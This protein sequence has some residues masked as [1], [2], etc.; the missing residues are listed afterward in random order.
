MLVQALA[1]YADTYMQKELGD[2]AFEKKPVPYAVEI[3]EQGRYLGVR[4]RMKEIFSVGGG[5]R[6]VPE[7]LLA[8]KSP[9][10]R[11]TG[12]HPLLGCDA[13]QYVVGPAPGVWTK[14]AEVEKH[15]RQ[16]AGFVELI[17]HSA[18]STKDNALNACSIFYR[19]AKS[20]EQARKD[21]VAKKPKPGAVALVV[22]PHGVDSEMVG[23]AIVER[24]LVQDY[25][26]KHFMKG[27]ED[28]HAR[29][30][31]GMCLVSGRSGRI[32]V[33]HEKIKGKWVVNLRGQA[34]GVSLMSFDK[35]AFRSYGWDQNANSPISPERATAYVLALNDL[36]QPG[37]HHQGRSAGVNLR[38]RT[39]HGCVAFLYWTKK[40]EDVDLYS[41]VENPMHDDVVR[42]MESVRR[43][44]ELDSRTVEPNA[45]FLLAV[46]GN[47]G[48]LVVRDWFHEQLGRVKCNIANW[49]GQLR[50]ADVFKSGV[51]SG[52]FPLQKMIAAL[53][54]PKTKADNPVNADRAMRMVRR[55]LCGTP[56]PASILVAAL[57]RLRVERGIDRLNPARIG[58]IR[59]CCN[60]LIRMK[61]Q[62]GGCLMTESLDNGQQHPAYICGRLLAV[63]EGMQ[64]QAQG[65]VGVTVAD[66]YYALAS[67]YPKLAFPKIETLGHAHIKKLRRDNPAAAVAIGR[68][69]DELTAGLVQYGGTYPAQLGLEDQG[70]FAIGYH[71]QKAEDQKNIAERSKAKR[72]QQ[73]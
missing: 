56:L 33:T 34:S 2:P 19:D 4:E 65:S 45:F 20:V 28:R 55:A 27:T 61:G 68:R 42:L 59:L 31:S 39:D 25:W 50:I 29:G 12:I 24:P 18:S 51:F 67:T 44:R 57:K 72:E 16:H 30:S 11:N 6:T 43:G 60:D 41:M 10:N 1:D 48:R 35:E 13:I 62:G 46:S 17:H 53:S 14:P 26:R 32:A 47:G 40:P 8:P 3:D 52:S 23:G 22:R 49:F 37:L 9:V 64:Y 15:S 21:L 58:L 66:R 73:S 69:I 63:Y 36:L 54:S 5:S 7:T 70:R 38:T 71:H